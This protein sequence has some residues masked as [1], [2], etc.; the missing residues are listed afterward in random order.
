MSLQRA[1]QNTTTKRGEMTAKKQIM[2][3]FHEGCC[4]EE[5]DGQTKKGGI[6]VMM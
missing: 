6:K 5:I 1:V 4:I 3:M 2:H